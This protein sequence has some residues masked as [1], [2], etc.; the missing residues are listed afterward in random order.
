MPCGRTLT[1][2]A[3]SARLTVP[4]LR[5][6]WMWWSKSVTRSQL[7][8][9]PA[10][11]EPL[12][13]RRGAHPSRDGLSALAHL[14]HRCGTALRP[15]PV[16]GSG[17]GALARVEVRDRARLGAPAPR[18]SRTVARDLRLRIRRS[19]LRGG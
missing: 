5:S 2:F 8:H 6:L 16:R 14:G 17:T 9:A 10:S 15:A 4:S 11:R 1:V 7:H 18:A 19:P 12:P 13:A 3:R